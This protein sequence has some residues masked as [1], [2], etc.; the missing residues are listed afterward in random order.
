MMGWHS[1][2]LGPISENLEK[3]DWTIGDKNLSL[4]GTG[5]LSSN[6]PSGEGGIM[7]ILWAKNY[8]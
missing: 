6:L 1:E 3:V 8:D 7:G 4:Y 5:I 2:M